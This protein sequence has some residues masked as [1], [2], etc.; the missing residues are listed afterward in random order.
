MYCNRARMSLRALKFKLRNS[1]NVGAV[2]VCTHLHLYLHL[3]L[4]TLVPACACLIFMVYGN[5][6]METNA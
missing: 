1:E 5:T 4:L 6:K 3:Y 2:N